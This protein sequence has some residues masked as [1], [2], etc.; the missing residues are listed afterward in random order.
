MNGD[1]FGRACL[2]PQPFPSTARKPHTICEVPSVA[3]SLAEAATRYAHRAVASYIR[4]DYEDFYL[5]AGIAL[6]QA[7]KARLARAN[8]AFIAPDRHFRSALALWQ[9][10]DDV[11]KLPIGTRTIGGSEALER[12]KELEP[13]FDRHVE[14]VRQV[15]RF[16][17]GEAHLG[18]PGSSEHRRVFSD[19]ARALTSLLRVAPAEFWGEHNN[20]IELAVDDSTAAVAR[21]V[22]EKMS[23]AT[24]TFRQRF[25]H[26]GEEQRTTLL[27]LAAH[28]ADRQAND[29]LLVWECPGCGHESALLSGENFV[30][31]DVEWDHRDRVQVDAS[32]FIEFRGHFLDCALCDL[33]LD[34]LEELEAAGM[35]PVFPNDEADLDEYMRDYYEEG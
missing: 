32:P 35:D 30:E 12:V 34:G 19:F 2:G 7:M 29:A 18:A 24:L 21:E 27:D 11:S 25:D 31:F 1:D 9:T 4:G 26:L 13:G 10:R 20:L 14:S 16:R 5:S 6:E 3:R 33:E 22:A 28:H 23:R 15:L 17:N 8:V